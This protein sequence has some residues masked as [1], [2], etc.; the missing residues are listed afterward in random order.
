MKMVKT[1]ANQKMGCASHVGWNRL[2][3]KDFIAVITEMVD[4]DHFIKTNSLNISANFSCLRSAD[5]MVLN[6]IKAP[7]LL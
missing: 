3:K 2:S 4:I 7:I 5:K 1:K 6:L